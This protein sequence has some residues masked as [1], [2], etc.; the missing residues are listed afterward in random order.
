[1]LRPPGD[2]DG[3]NGDGE[4][5]N[6]TSA[7]G[8]GHVIQLRHRLSTL[9]LAG[10]WITSAPALAEPSSITFFSSVGYVGEQT[11]LRTPAADIDVR[12]PLLSARVSGGRWEVCSK[13]G[14]RGQCIVVDGEERNFKR[15]FGFFSR[16]S[17]AR[18]LPAGGAPAAAPLAA[19]AIAPAEPFM[20]DSADVAEA[21]FY[22]LPKAAGRLLPACDA[23]EG[24]QCGAARA[25]QFC[26]EEGR[27][28]ARYFAVRRR[29]GQAVIADL[30][31]T[32][33]R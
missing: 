9:L 5:G 2:G 28:D 24:P 15:A 30:L 25:A 27:Q 10:A 21:L 20:T 1:M 6:L 33:G 29:G 12:T 4:W 7:Q 3:K 22:R 18:P 8:G 13:N 16:V 11:V 19:A 26:R 32:G 23:G 31:C 17:S 14:F